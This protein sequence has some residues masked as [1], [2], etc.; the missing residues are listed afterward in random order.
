MNMTTEQIKEILPHREPFLLLDRVTA[1][2]PGVFADAE[3]LLTGDEFFFPG[4]FPG[5]PVMP[6]VLILEAMAQ[7]A[8]VSV[9]VTEENHG[10]TVMLC[11]VRNAK[12]SRPVYPGDT[13]QLHSELI[14]M[15]GSMGSV[16]TSAAV[17]G[18]VC[19]TAD[20]SFAIV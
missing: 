15:L 5:N 9:L 3:K 7:C 19:A 18:E 17:G 12:F 14:K 11:G 16:R 20:L 8:A 6:G 4:H 1:C 10:K 13:L 2:E